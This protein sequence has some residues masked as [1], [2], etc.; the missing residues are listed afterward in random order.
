MEWSPGVGVEICRKIADYIEG[1]EARPTNY[2]VFTRD[3]LVV[4]CGIRP[5]VFCDESFFKENSCVEISRFIEWVRK[6]TGIFVA[7][8]VY[9]DPEWTV[10]GNTGVVYLMNVEL[11]KR[12]CESAVEEG[13]VPMYLFGTKQGVGMV[14][15]REILTRVLVEAVVGILARIES[16]PEKVL[17]LAAD[18]G[19]REL[20]PMLN[21]WMLEYPVIYANQNSAVDLEGEEVAQS[22]NDKLIVR[23]YLPSAIVSPKPHKFTGG[24]SRQ[25]FSF[26]VP[27]GVLTR[28]E[29]VEMKRG[30][31]HQIQERKPY[32]DL[33]GPVSVQVDEPGNVVWAS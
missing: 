13:I 9:K 27:K 23:C 10:K 4:V 26:T 5:V 31:E 22:L 21:G 15:Q 2:R 18:T 7:A 12:K 32:Q 11:L 25:L 28:D 33:W 16:G 19:V 30:L 6:L 20:V 1:W 14:E 24:K 29:I 17:D 8:M 3:L